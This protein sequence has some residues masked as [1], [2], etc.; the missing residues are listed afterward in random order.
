[1]TRTLVIVP[2]MYTR[3]EFRKLCSELPEDFDARTR[4]FWSYVRERMRALAGRVRWVFRDGVTEPAERGLASLRGIDP[5]SF[6]VIEELLSRGAQLQIVEDKLL[7]GEVEAWAQMLGSSPT[8]AVRELLEAS[9]RERLD[10]IVKT[11]DRSL[12]DGEVGVLL[13]D[14]NVEVAPPND[15]RVIRMYPFHPRDYLQSS[16]AKSK[17]NPPRG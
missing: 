6:T 12:K 3:D 2:R 1:M 8:V 9:L 7:L 13:L 17:V 15:A 5:E 4:E 10:H 14:A 11:I 16:L